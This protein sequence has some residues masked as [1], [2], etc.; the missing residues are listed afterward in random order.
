MRFEMLNMK[1]YEA[2]MLTCA[3][4]LEVRYHERT[5]SVFKGFLL[6]VLLT[7][8]IDSHA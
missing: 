2:T 1:R 3:R 7:L 5:L 8:K 4:L 6:P